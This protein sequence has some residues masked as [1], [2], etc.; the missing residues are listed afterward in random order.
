MKAQ[1]VYALNR[2]ASEFFDI[3]EVELPEPAAGQ[4]RVR[5]EAAGVSYGDLLLQRGVIPGGPKPPFV[6]GFDLVGVVE[7]VGPGVVGL[8]AGDRVAALVREGG[9]STALN[10]PAER[11]VPVPDGVDPTQAAAVTLNYFIAHQMLHRVAD[12]RGGHR[13]L[14]HGASGGVGLAFLQLAG[15]IGDVTVWGTASAG[16]ADLLRAAGASPIDYRGEDFVAVVKAAGANLRAVFDP[17]GGTHFWRSYSVLGRGGYLVGYGQSKALRDGRRDMR[18]GALGFLGGIIAP[19]LLPDGRQTVFY[20]AW[21]LERSQPAAY[22][23]DLAQ[24]LRLL[25]EGR[26]APRA[27]TALPLAEAERVVRELAAPAGASGG[28]FVLTGRG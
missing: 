18:V 4:A 21:A 28:K 17:M 3:R 15:L 11:L 23:E 7:S 9:Y 27:V 16:N 13:I 14:V 25:A 5:V 2:G 1:R 12:V 19:K 6:P 24:V 20:N 26:I 22:R 8:A 10:V